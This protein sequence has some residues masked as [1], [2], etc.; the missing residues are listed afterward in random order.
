ML[1]TSVW[2]NSTVELKRRTRANFRRW[3]VEES[4]R[5]E[6]QG[7]GIEQATVRHYARL[8][9]CWGSP[10]SAGWCWSRLTTK[11]GFAMR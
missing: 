11:V 3:G 6:K 7:F 8:K 1:L 9:P 4:Y 10:C 5:F 2:V